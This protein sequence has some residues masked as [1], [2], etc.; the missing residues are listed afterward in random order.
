MRE[1]LAT[2][3][4]ASGAANQATAP[5]V[6]VQFW[7][8]ARAVPGLDSW[9]PLETAGFER[10]LFGDTSARHFIEEHFSEWHVRAFDRCSHP[11]RALTT[12]GFVSCCGSADCMSMPTTG[13]KALAS[14][15]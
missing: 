14:N 10:L 1:L 6:L 4:G 11:P 2:R 12:S 9:A 7:D 8:D 5:R 3:I 15:Q 13:T